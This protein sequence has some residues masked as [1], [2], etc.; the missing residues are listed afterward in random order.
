MKKQKVKVFKLTMTILAIAIIVGIIIYMFPVMRKLSTKEGQLAF[1]EKVSSSGILGLLMLFALQVAQIF[2]IIIPGEP[3]EILAGMCY[4]PIW[5]TVFIMVSAGIISTIIFSLV[6]KY[7]KRFVYNFCD[8]EKVAKIENSKLFKNPNKIEM[9]MFIL[10]LLPG[11]PK[12]LL[13]YT[14]GLLPINPVKFVLISVFAR[15]PSVISSTLAG[16]NLAVGD[17]KK[18]IVMYLSIVFVAIIV[19]LIANKFDKGKLA[20]KAIKTIK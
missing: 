16:A 11:T 15:F 10:F 7:G 14:A 3:I 18:S 9:I 4:G 17:W 12:D 6:R 1:K 2:L 5:G 19:I 8:K 20:E 13:A